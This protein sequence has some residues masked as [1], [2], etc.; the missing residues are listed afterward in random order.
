[1]VNLSPE[2]S[3]CSDGR[4]ASV[5]AAL[6]AP[7]RFAGAVLALTVALSAAT[8]PPAA[9]SPEQAPASFRT[10]SGLR[11]ELVAAEPLVVDPVAFAFDERGRLYVVE[12]RGYPDVPDKPTR[13]GR[14][15]LLEDIDR[16]GR[17]DRR[18]E[19]AGGYTHPNGIA[20][21]RGGVF[22]TCAPDIHYLKD[23]N[24]DGVADQRTVVLTG[25]QTGASA[26]NYASHPTLGLDGKIYVTCGLRSGGTVTSPLHPGRPAVEFPPMDGR[27]DPDRFDFE[28]TGGRSQFGLAFDAFGRR[29]V[30]DNR[31]PVLQVML[32]PAHLR[33]NPYL[34]FAET[35]QA[36]SKV[37]AEAKVLRVSRAAVTADFIP[38]LMSTPHAG[39][40]TSACGLV[41][42]EGSG[43]PAAYQGNVFIC[44]PAQNLV[45]RQVLRPHGASFRS[46]AVFEDGAE[47]MASTDIAFR[48]VFLANGPGGALYVADM[49]RAEIDHPTFIPEEARGA[50]DFEAGKGTGRIYRVIDVA[51]DPRAEQPRFESLAEL[52]GALESRDA[53]TRETARRLLLERAD[54][55]AT[56]RL[57]ALAS[58]SAQAGA[59]CSALWLLRHFDGLTT[60]VHA[61]ALHDPDSRVREQGVILATSRREAMPG[62]GQR[63]AAMASDPDARV[64]FLVALGLGTV[65]GPEAI[66]ALAAIVRR[67]ADDRWTRAAVA[68]GIGG[69][70]PDFIAALLA[71][72]TEETPPSLGLI[73]REASRIVGAGGTPAEVRRLLTRAKAAG[74]DARWLVAVT[75]GLTEGAVAREPSRRATSRPLAPLLAADAVVPGDEQELLQH[76]TGLALDESAGSQDRANAAALLGYGDFEL[77]GVPLGELLTMRHPAELRLEAVRSLERIGDVRG[78]GLLIRPELWSGY[79]APL[80][81]AVVSALS[82]RREWAEVLFAAVERGTIRPA[83][84]STL[85][86]NFLL[87]RADPAVR[88]K[89]AVLFEAT[90]HDRMQVYRGHLDVLKL[91]S[92]AARGEGVF[93]RVCASCH[94][95]EARGGNIGPDLTGIR[96]Q[97]REAILLH[98]LVPNSEIAPDYASVTLTLKDGGSRAGRIIAE[99]ATSLTLRT[100][101]GADEAILRSAIGSLRRAGLS[102]MPDGLEQAMTRQELA[103][104]IAYLKSDV[105]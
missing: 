1:M 49:N 29:F 9:L 36:V 30:C 55:A 77:S 90:T 39:T 74:Q 12:A 48:P 92:A 35:T 2:N 69:R 37:Q 50:L 19:F 38:A 105:K 16:D 76:A 81:V 51:I 98:T 94:T 4:T 53:W 72:S 63:L 43:L 57:A 41:V 104:L 7:V 84:I 79:D 85:Q 22:V 65:A 17:F 31:N 3:G 27:F 56:S 61:R 13:E 40:F 103:D 45:Q 86:R 46:A 44:E 60:E 68:S 59:R 47:F 91:E 20:V 75:L 71:R 28:T 15:A 21:W 6:N 101:E 67:D 73:I 102:L 25:F 52:L 42:F 18:T 33:R 14:V 10:G 87:R 32:E 93:V 97:P 89:A 100:V 70:A 88:R 8:S 82:V 64:R 83:E 99:T 95:Y 24:G 5:A 78:A 80:R 26:Q 54:R 66:D 11:V 58:D 96:H 23:H 34:Q 62:L